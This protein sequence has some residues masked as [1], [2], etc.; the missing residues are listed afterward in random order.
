M[1]L[2]SRQSCWLTLLLLLVLLGLTSA[3]ATS[4][5]I[6]NTPEEIAFAQEAVQEILLMSLEGASEREYPV[7][8]NQTLTTYF[9]PEEANPLLAHLNRIPGADRLLRRYLELMSTAANSVIREMDEVFRPIILSMLIPKP[10][11]IIDGGSSAATTFFIREQGEQLRLEI[12]KKLS[13]AMDTP[14]NGR[15]ANDGWRD[16]RM[17]YNTQ[18]IARNQLELS[19]LPLLESDPLAWSAVSIWNVFSGGMA[20]QEDLIRATAASFDSPAIALF[21][22][23]ERD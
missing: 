10:F 21:I 9:I 20:A 7:L 19:S 5:I 4:R 23:K 3:C 6:Q 1:H 11:S 12:Q 22:I 14:I 17:L 16:L 8:A 2:H 13:L 15:T 18:A